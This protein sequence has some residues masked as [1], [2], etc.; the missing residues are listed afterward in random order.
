MKLL[1]LIPLL[2]SLAACSK[3][4]PVKEAES[5]ELVGSDSDIKEQAKSI[6]DAADE[7]AGIVESEANEEIAAFEGAEP[8][9]ETESEPAEDH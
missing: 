2:F 1:V 8:D 5:V 9:V 7:A 3:S 4:A 6:D